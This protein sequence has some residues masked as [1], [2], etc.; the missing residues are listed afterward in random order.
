MNHYPRRFFGLAIVVVLTAASATACQVSC[1]VFEVE[2][3]QV[4]LLN[5]EGEAMRHAKV[6][7]RRATPNPQHGERGYCEM[8]IGTVVRRLSTNKNGSFSLA[9]LPEGSY[10][11]SYDDAEAG[12]SFQI[13]LKSTGVRELKL[14]TLGGLCYLVDIEHNTTRP[15]G[16]WKPIRVE[17]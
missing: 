12:E 2:A 5:F 1:R 13:E 6:I 16:R 4:T 15:P 3:G 14:N 11:V 7:I 9:N 8:T 17:P 10:W